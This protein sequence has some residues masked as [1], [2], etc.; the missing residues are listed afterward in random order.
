MGN[1]NCRL[2]V[3]YKVVKV[4][5]DY[6]LFSILSSSI[7]QQSQTERVRASELPNSKSC[8]SAITH[9]HTPLPHKFPFSLGFKFPFSIFTSIAN[10]RVLRSKKAEPFDKFRFGEWRLRAQQ[11]LDLVIP[12]LL[13]ETPSDPSVMPS[14]SL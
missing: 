8:S 13:E 4:L 10:P 14:D 12:P 9:S 5:L 11:V 3:Y 6:L 1:C 2:A 7:S